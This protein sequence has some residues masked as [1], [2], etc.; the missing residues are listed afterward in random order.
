[1]YCLRV[2]E[3]M[4]LKSEHGGCGWGVSSFAGLQ[5]E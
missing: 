2:L 1:M 5:E 3:A 4:S